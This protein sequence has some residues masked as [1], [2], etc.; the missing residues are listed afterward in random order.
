MKKSYWGY[1]RYKAHEGRVARGF[2]LASS[3]GEAE[4]KARRRVVVERRRLTRTEGMTFDSIP[5]RGVYAIRVWRDPKRTTAPLTAK[6][7][8]ER[9]AS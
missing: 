8:T 6:H 5:R 4:K 2:V 3:R 9:V 7:Y 1:C